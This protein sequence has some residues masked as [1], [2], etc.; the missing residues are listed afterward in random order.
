M[1]TAGCRWPTP[2]T[3]LTL[4]RR[5]RGPSWFNVPKSTTASRCRHPRDLSR[6][7]SALIAKPERCTAPKRIVPSSLEIH[8]SSLHRPRLARPLPDTAAS[9]TAVRASG[10]TR[11][12]TFRPRALSAPRRL[13]PH[14]APTGLLHPAS[15]HG[16]HTVSGFL[17]PPAPP[18]RAAEGTRLPHV[19]FDPSKNSPHLQPVRVTAPCCLL[20]VSIRTFPE[21]HHG[22]LET[23]RA[24]PLRPRSSNHTR[25]ISPTQAYTSTKSFHARTRSKPAAAHPSDTSPGAV[26]AEAKTNPTR[27]SLF[28]ETRGAAPVHEDEPTGSELPESILAKNHPLPDSGTSPT[29]W[30]EVHAKCEAASRR[31]GFPQHRSGHPRHD[32]RLQGL[33]PQVSP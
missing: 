28:P 31:C 11:R 3:T 26:L 4:R 9:D 8:G 24:G 16:I 7:F 29:E 15:G 27:R 19:C 25:A 5:R 20:D 12:L 14:R 10:A 18:K 33:T 22:A 2:E 30:V 6:A 21:S 23:V 32:G 13:A 1:E 17:P